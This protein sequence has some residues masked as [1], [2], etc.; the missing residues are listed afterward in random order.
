[1]AVSFDNGIFSVEDVAG[2]VLAGSKLYFYT[3]GTSTPLATYSDQAL[4]I[5]NANPVVADASGRFGAIWLQNAD[6]KVVLKSSADVT[7]V[8]R[9]PVKGGSVITTAVATVA[10]MTALAKAGLVNNQTIRV[11][12][13]TSIGDGGGGSFYW[14][15][16][17]STTANVGTV[18]AANEGGTGRWK[19][20]LDS[21][22]I[23]VKW[24]GATGDGATDDVAALQATIDYVIA[25]GRREV[26]APYGTYK[27]TT[28]INITKPISIVGDGPENS[29]LS[30]SG[31]VTGINASMALSSDWHFKID[32]LGIVNTAALNTPSSGAGIRLNLAYL[33]EITN[34]KIKN[35]YNGLHITQSP[36]TKV[37]GLHIDYFTNDGI[38]IDG[39]NNFNMWFSEFTV[40][41]HLFA[42]C[43]GL[44]MVDMN[45]AMRFS[46]GVFSQCG[47][48]MA[49]DA[50]S[51][52][53][54]A[55]PEFCTFTSVEFDDCLDGP[56]L[57]NCRD[58]VF[59]AC[60]FSCRPGVGLKVSPNKS[61]D[62][63]HVND[64]TFL[65]CGGNGL[66]LGA[67]SRGFRSKNSNYVNNSQ[68]SAGVAH[69]AAVTDGA[70]NFEFVG[71][72]FG[73]DWGGAG[74]QNFGLNIAGATCNKFVVAFNDFSAAT[75]NT[76]VNSS[77]AAV[78]KI[79]GNIGYLDDGTATYDPGSLADGAGVTTT[80]TVTGAALGDIAVASFS[81]DLQGITLTA[82]VSAANT[83]SVRFQNESGGVLDLAS[84]TLKVRV[85]K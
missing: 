16:I 34:I 59:D 24:F 26:R 76:F 25:S 35:F 82:W 49:T 28:Q 33:A 72:K 12:G 29:V 18:F 58:M 51:Y 55:I 8:T 44:R 57:D 75:G 5:A 80:V 41:G 84:G 30:F 73:N 3:T 1:M 40:S 31:N 83:V 23:D 79:Y 15:S 10:A 11:A 7:L 17:S 53:L 32:G 81:L 48:A 47:I 6:Y 19:R 85:L 43:T 63:I 64:C 4:T 56:N 60:F 67:L 36:L 27:C 38:R 14:D 66:S 65:S 2:A 61:T 62:A 54:S 20:V 42:T 77:T 37:S 13:Y 39:G 45:D 52:T 69:G 50:T 74:T 68:A 9:D 78:Q 70:T 22:P 21:G 71:D 46:D